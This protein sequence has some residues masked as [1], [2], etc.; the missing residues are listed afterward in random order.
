MLVQRL[1]FAVVGLLTGYSG[2][3]VHFLFF[4]VLISQLLLSLPLRLLLP[5][6]QLVQKVAN[7]CLAFGLHVLSD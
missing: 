7:V 1:H 2:G 6:L 5:N 4:F 3:L